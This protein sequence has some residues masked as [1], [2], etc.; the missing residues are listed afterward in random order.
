[1][2]VGNYWVADWYAFSIDPSESILYQ[3]Y[4]YPRVLLWYSGVLILLLMMATVWIITEPYWQACY[5][6]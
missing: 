6:K 2:E 3:S 1:M 4:L 5:G